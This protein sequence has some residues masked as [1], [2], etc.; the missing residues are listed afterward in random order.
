MNIIA[1]TAVMEYSVRT[2]NLPA[3]ED[4]N[5]K[6]DRSMRAGAVATGCG[7]SIVTMPG[8]LPTI[9]VKDTRAIL[10]AI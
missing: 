10:E 3:I 5:R 2:N 7:A 9:P 1:D 6:F 4:A 8:Y